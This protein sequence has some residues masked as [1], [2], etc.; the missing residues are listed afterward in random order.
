MYP[1]TNPDANNNP[2]TL[3]DTIPRHLWNSPL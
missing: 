3:T 2:N 1:G